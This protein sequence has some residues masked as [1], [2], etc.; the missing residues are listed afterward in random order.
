MIIN[1]KPSFGTYEV[2]EMKRDKS[3]IVIVF[4]RGENMGDLFRSL[5]TLVHFFTFIFF[6]TL[7][8]ILLQQSTQAKTKSKRGGDQPNYLSCRMYYNSYTAFN[9]NESVR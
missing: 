7:L 5:S 3:W 1:F 9:I 2:V 4:S 6:F 8:L